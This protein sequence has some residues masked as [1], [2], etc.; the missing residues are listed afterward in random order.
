[1]INSKSKEKGE[2]TL[3]LQMCLS[4]KRVETHLILVFIPLI[5]VDFVVRSVLPLVSIILVLVLPVV[6]LPV[7]V[8]ITVVIIVV[9]VG[10]SSGVAGGVVTAVVRVDISIILG[11]AV[12]VRSHVHV[13]AVLSLGQRTFVV[14]EG[15]LILLVVEGSIHATHSVAHGPR[16]SVCTQ[17]GSP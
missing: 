9:A 16:W 4:T 13:V 3:G 2:L 10:G 11:V 17:I 5:L 15:T 1:M 8:V 7:V 12:S 6:S 14:V